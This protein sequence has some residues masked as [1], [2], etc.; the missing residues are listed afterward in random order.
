M[1]LTWSNSRDSARLA[2][3]W[4]WL[5]LGMGT[6]GFVTLCSLVLEI[7]IIVNEEVKSE[8]HFTKWNNQPPKEQ[9][10]VSVLMTS[11]LNSNIYACILTQETTINIKQHWMMFQ[12]L[13]KNKQKN[14]QTKKELSTKLTSSLNQFLIIWNSGTTQKSLLTSSK[15]QAFITSSY[16]CFSYFFP[17][18]MLLLTVPGN[19]HGC[20]ET[21]AILPCTLTF[22]WLG[23]SSPSRARNSDDWNR[24]HHT[25][26]NRVHSG[27]N[28]PRSTADPTLVLHKQ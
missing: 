23:G 4:T 1:G 3:S 18:K 13:R 6:W 21:Y 7:F 12:T 5:K 19:S 11:G 8:W 16:R 14:K 25:L 26:V 9:H 10:S 24:G 22:P 20:W 28:K 27:Q 2:T 17:N 15:A